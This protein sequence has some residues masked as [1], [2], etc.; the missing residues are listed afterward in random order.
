[1]NTNNQKREFEAEGKYNSEKTNN[2][3]EAYESRDKSISDSSI[4]IYGNMDHSIA[5]IGTDSVINFHHIEKNISKD[6]IIELVENLRSE[7][8]ESISDQDDYDVI[9]ADLDFVEK[10][11][12]KPEPKKGMIL[13]KIKSILDLI[14]MAAAASQALPELISKAERLF[15]W[16]MTLLS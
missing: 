8:K 3:E 6:D 16:V 13:A 9:E 14:P 7:L 1:M 11:L 15:E 4:N 10:Q 5:H 2:K 12:E